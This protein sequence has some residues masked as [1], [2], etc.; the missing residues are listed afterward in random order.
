MLINRDLRRKL[1]KIL[2]LFYAKTLIAPVPAEGIIKCSDSIRNDLVKFKFCALA[3]GTSATIRNVNAKIPTL[4]STSGLV[5]TVPVGEA[6]YHW[7]I[8]M[9]RFGCV[10][11]HGCSELYLQLRTLSCIPFGKS[12]S[13]HCND[14]YW[15]AL[16]NA[17]LEP[18]HRSL[19]N[20]RIWL[21]KCKDEVQSDWR[22][23]PTLLNLGLEQG[24]RLI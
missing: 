17:S 20:N 24:D 3:P 9:R 21:V 6:A 15:T 4:L 1:M 13:D 16:L 11:Y 22:P 12:K 18:I 7:Y 14:N 2:S 8:E 23:I 19:P 10:L 5:A